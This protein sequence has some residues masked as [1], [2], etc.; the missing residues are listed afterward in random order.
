M[1]N[2]FVQGR[3]KIFSGETKTPAPL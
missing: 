2:T 3:A 1:S